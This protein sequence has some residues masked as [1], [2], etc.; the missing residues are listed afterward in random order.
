MNIIN[1][2][3]NRFL[4]HWMLSALLI[5]PVSLFICLMLWVPVS[6]VLSY[7]G[8]WEDL[9][10]F[11]PIIGIIA[12]FI[13]SGL[14]V[15]YVIGE[16]QKILVEDELD[17]YLFSWRKTSAVGGMC[18]SLL[19]MFILY[20]ANSLD[21][22]TRWMLVMPIFMLVLSSFQWLK[23]RHMTHEAWL[24]ILGNMTAACVFSGLLFMNQPDPFNDYYSFISFCLW[25]LATLAQSL[26]MGIVLLWL[27]NRPLLEDN[28]L[29]PVY[30]EVRNHDD[31]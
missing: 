18:A 26:I 19:V 21:L 11:V 28:E 27:Y 31:Y 16:A 29:A 20:W 1:E 23:M 9:T 10:S 7:L 15:G 3:P 8:H 14:V 4:V 30:L 2:K 17:W 5:W 6:F 22:Q 24:W 25:I 12:M 13:I